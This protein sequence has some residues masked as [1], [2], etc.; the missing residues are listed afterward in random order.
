MIQQKPRSLPVEIASLDEQITTAASALAESR[1][2]EKSVAGT[3]T[4][5]FVMLYALAGLVFYFV[6]FAPGAL[7][8]RILCS[9]PLLVSPPL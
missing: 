3:L 1:R 4:I 8:E 9:L 6:Y 7:H 5:A 2:V